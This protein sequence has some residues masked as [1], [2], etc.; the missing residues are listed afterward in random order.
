MSSLA[1]TERV[2]IA[3]IDKKSRDLKAKLDAL[4]D[5][6]KVCFSLFY[7]PCCYPNTAYELML[8]RVFL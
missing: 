7:H 2:T 6:E 3:E 5:F 8:N 4:S 1:Q